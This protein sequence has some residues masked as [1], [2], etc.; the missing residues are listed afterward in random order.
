MNV[1]GCQIWFYNIKYVNKSYTA[2]R[3]VIWRIWKI[4]YR[5]HNKLLH[6]IND[7]IP[8][9]ITLEKKGALSSYGAS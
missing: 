8:I 2:W 7:C 1:Y 5:T 3:T 6:D 4:D 9:D